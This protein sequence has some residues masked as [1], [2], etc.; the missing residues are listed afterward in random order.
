MKGSPARL[1]VTAPAAAAPTARSQFSGDFLATYG[2]EGQR[3][4]S[5][6]AR[7]EPAANGGFS[8]LLV[9]NRS[10]MESRKGP[11]PCIRVGRV[12]AGRISVVAVAP[13]SGNVYR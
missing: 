10:V 4:E 5:S 3:F 7:R 1:A 12:F 6:R 2:T 11:E 13:V 9:H 8:R